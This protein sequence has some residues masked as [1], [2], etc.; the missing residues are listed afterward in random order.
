[1]KGRKI[2]QG[3]STKIRNIFIMRSIKAEKHNIGKRSSD[4]QVYG[5]LLKKLHNEND[6]R[7]AG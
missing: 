5:V 6:M 2:V 7:D 3:C 4:R 1:M